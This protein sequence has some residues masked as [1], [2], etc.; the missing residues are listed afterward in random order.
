MKKIVYVGIGDALA[1]LTK[2]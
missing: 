1:A 2:R